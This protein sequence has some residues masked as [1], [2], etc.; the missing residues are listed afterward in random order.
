MKDRALV[1]AVFNGDAS[2]GAPVT[3]YYHFGQQYQE[4]DVHAD[5]EVAYYERF[6]P[7]ILKVM[8]DYSFPCPD[9]MTRLTSPGDIDAYAHSTAHRQPF[10][11]QLKALSSVRQQ[12]GQAP[13][14]WDTV[15]N[16]WFA[17]RRNLLCLDIETYMREEPARLHQLLEIVADAIAGHIVS[18]LAAGADGILYSVPASEHFLSRTD[19]RT[20]MLPYDLKVIEQV[21][22]HTD[23]FVVHIHGAGKIYHEDVF[24]HYPHDGLSWADRTTNLSLTDARRKS[25]T[26]LM[27]G[28]DETNDFNYRP[29]DVF[30]A[31]M[32]EAVQAMAGTP[33][34]LSPGCVLPPQCPT[35]R[36]AF[37]FE[38][39]RALRS[40][41]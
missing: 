37:M 9:G 3:A 8:N 21:K 19:F 27:G 39:A 38:T 34:I 12:L 35:E 25:D 14:I 17:I 5:L 7:D 24:T 4:G 31:E 15:F 23:M 20:F 6:R 33:F 30:E 36:L 22:R 10:P 11:E 1:N 2:Y 26:V 32:R 28:I 41:H 16:P 40:K 18:S 13:V 29:Y